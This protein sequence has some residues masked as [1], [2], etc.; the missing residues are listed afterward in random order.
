MS[1]VMVLTYTVYNEEFVDQTYIGGGEYRSN[2][3]KVRKAIAAVW[4]SDPE[5]FG[6][7]VAY[8]RNHGCTARTLIDSPD[9]LDRAK[10]LELSEVPA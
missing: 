4:S 5:R 9:V 6:E 8:A 2:F 10:K 7:G 1:A 3:R